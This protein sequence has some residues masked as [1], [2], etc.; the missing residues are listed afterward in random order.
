DVD[1]PAHGCRPILK[2]EDRNRA[3]QAKHETHPWQPGWSKS[4][5]A[6]QTVNGVRRECVDNVQSFFARCS[7]CVEKIGLVLEDSDECAVTDRAY[8]RDWPCRRGL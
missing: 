1:G 7:R 2:Q 6:I 4:H 3:Q 5:G 8:R